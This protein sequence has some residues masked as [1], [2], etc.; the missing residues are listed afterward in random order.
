MIMIMIMFLSLFYHCKAICSG[1]CRGRTT[2]RRSRRIRQRPGP[3][4]RSRTG[5]DLTDPG[6]SDVRVTYHCHLSESFMS[7]GCIASRQSSRQPLPGRHPSRSSG[8]ASRA[9]EEPVRGPQTSRDRGAARLEPTTMRVRVICP[10]HIS[11]SARTA[12]RLGSA[13]SSLGPVTGSPAGPI[14]I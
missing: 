14:S 10:G 12:G 13:R 11:E 2:A 5:G 3:A 7:V 6:Q 8:S 9:G 1:E 4:W